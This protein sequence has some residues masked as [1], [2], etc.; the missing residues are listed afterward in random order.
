MIEHEKQ[1]IS[2]LL[3]SANAYYD[4]NFTQNKILDS[5]IHR[6]DG[7]VCSI[8][9]LED[10]NGKYTYLDLVKYWG[11]R[12]EPEEKVAY[13]DF[14]DV[15]KIKERYENG[16]K[17]ITFKYWTED[18]SGQ[19]MLSVHHI[20][21]F[22]DVDSDDLLGLA[23]LTF[24]KTSDDIIAEKYKEASNRVLLLENL[25][26]NVPGGYHR[27]HSS[28]G[29][30]LA[31]VSDS[32]L[33]VVG[34]TR[35]QIREELDNKYLNIVAPEDREFFLGHEEELVKN[36]RVDLTYR[37]VRRDGSRR[38]IQDATIMM[39]K[40]GE[41]YYQCTLSDITDYV[42]RLNEEKAK[43][44]ASSLAKSTFLFNASHDIRT[45]MNAISG[46]ARIIAENVNNPEVVSDAVS[47][48]LQSS[49]MLSTLVND[50]LEVSRIER[51]KADVEQRPLD[52][53]E[54]VD[55]LH[56]MFTFE[57]KQADIEFVVENHI[58]HPLVI[59]DDL[60]LTRIAMN[61][62]SNAKKFTPA[63]GKVIFGVK[64]TDYDGESAAYTLYVKD[65]GIG[66]SREFQKRAFEQFE[67]ER[68]STETG[69][70]GSGLGLAIIKRL[71]ELMNGEYNIESELG[72]GTEITVKVPLKLSKEV[73]ATYD[74]NIDYTLFKGKRIL[75]VED[76]EF[77]REIACYTLNNAGFVVEEAE[78][79]FIAVDKLLKAKPN[80][81]DLVLM[82]I[83][84]PIM[85]GYTATKEIRNIENKEI[86]AVPIIAMTA[87]AFDEDKQ[88]CISCGMNGH[89]GKPLDVE[90]LMKEISKILANQ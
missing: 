1:L 7:T 89:I 24:E 62:L 50:V 74:E 86:A 9:D 11:D 45:P 75:L 25:S 76:N 70:I 67:R 37:I 79:G 2:A 80:Y 33:E 82:D 56:E 36:G 47:K 52:M 46:Y 39:E 71:C 13:Y 42:E 6:D 66:M 73:A 17:L 88:K 21:V 77:N 20:R 31:F 28:E 35:E 38:W 8:K 69:V 65:T 29:F 43:A 10:I 5:A 51:G 64:E 30:P 15:E 48:I 26:V 22:K 34:W 83:Q 53:E 90:V 40:N 32:F 58:Q 78:N 18:S 23:Y 72:K 63:G 54:H 3:D 55:K 61:L 49:D 84:M 87:N 14:Y 12:I 4:I 81:Y 59:G 41:I 27:C 60:K 19:P 85:N 57:M 44:E 16:E 68:S